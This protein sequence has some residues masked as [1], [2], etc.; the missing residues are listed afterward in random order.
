[1]NYAVWL[2]IGGKKRKFNS[3][4]RKIFPAVARSKTQRW[5]L[6]RSGAGVE[7]AA[8]PGWRGLVAVLRPDI[9]GTARRRQS[10]QKNRR[11][12]MRD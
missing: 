2:I 1:M 4:G 6:N 8:A 10:R 12:A 5:L 3:N 7:C 9:S 11:K